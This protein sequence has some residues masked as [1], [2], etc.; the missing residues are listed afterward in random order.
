MQQF[1][2]LFSL[3]KVESCSLAECCISLWQLL[4]L[5]HILLCVGHL[6]RCVWSVEVQ[7]RLLA[8]ETSRKG[9]QWIHY[10]KL[11]RILL[12]WPIHWPLKS[13]PLWGG[14][15]FISHSFCQYTIFVSS[16]TK[17][18]PANWA[19]W[20][21]E[22]SVIVLSPLSSQFPLAIHPY[23]R[24]HPCAHTEHLKF[25]KRKSKFSWFLT[26]L[27][28]CVIKDIILLVVSFVLQLTLP[29]CKL[30]GRVNKLCLGR[31]SPAIPDSWSAYQCTQ[32]KPSTV[33]F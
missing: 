29:K 30:S 7:T 13:S 23:F 2:D 19:F 17:Q 33:F 11:E 22:L 8:G 31:T 32:G 16:V 20:I 27:V 1:W 10:H 14:T 9:R 24:K 18:Q 28:G 26:S 25:Y 5:L 4:S 3:H 15:Q 12:S 6:E 21:A